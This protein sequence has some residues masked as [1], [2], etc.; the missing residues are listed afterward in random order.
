MKHELEQ[1]LK[2][3]RYCE[4]VP[5][6][7][8]CIRRK[9]CRSPKGREFCSECEEQRTKLTEL[10]AHYNLPPVILDSYDPPPDEL[11]ERE[12]LKHWDECLDL[13]IQEAVK[14]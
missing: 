3:W 4:L 11:S 9:S 14:V 8:N 12:K 2:Y 13:A 7:L 10:V 1:V 6:Q 5:I